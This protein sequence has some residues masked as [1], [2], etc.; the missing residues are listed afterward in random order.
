MRHERHGFTLIELMIVIA[1]VGILAAIA[2]PNY[3]RFQGRNKQSEVKLNLKALYTAAK[4]QYAEHATFDVGLNILTFSPEPNYRYTYSYN[5]STGTKQHIGSP[6]GACEAGI[7]SV[8]T[9]NTFVATGC[10]NLDNDPFVDSW[11]IDDTMQL[12]NGTTSAASDGSDL[13]H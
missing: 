11:R 5:A 13:S 3:Q 9:Q 10:G 1:I 4:A 2:L 7:T 6:G 8:V 12:W